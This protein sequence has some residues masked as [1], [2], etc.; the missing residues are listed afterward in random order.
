M[1]ALATELAQV[2]EEAA[3]REQQLAAW[4]HLVFQLSGGRI[5]SLDPAHIEAAVVAMRQACESC[6]MCC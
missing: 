6:C 3:A 5:T 1:R 4:K 2:A